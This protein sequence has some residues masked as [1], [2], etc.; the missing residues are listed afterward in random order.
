[1]PKKYDFGGYATK[2]GVKCTDG[3]IINR[4]AF[5]NCNGI[6]VPIVYQHVHDRLENVVGHGDLELRQDGMYVYGKINETPSGKLVKTMI[7]NGDLDSLSIYANQLIQNGPNVTHGVIREVSVVLAGANPQA[8]I[9]DVAIAHADGSYD[10]LE[11]EVVIQGFGN[12]DFLEHAD[13][14]EDSDEETIKDVYNT[15]NDKQKQVVQLILGSVIEEYENNDDDEEAEDEV[16]QS[17]IEEDNTMKKN[18]FAGVDDNTPSVSQADMQN[19]MTSARSLGSFRAAFNALD[20]NQRNAF[21]RHDATTYQVPLANEVRTFTEKA[22][23]VS[24]IGLLFPD[25]RDV[26]N[27]PEWIKRDTEWVAGV[28]NGVRHTPFSHIRTSFADITADEA[29][30]KGYITGHRKTEEVFSVLRRDTTATTVYKKQKF[31]RDDIVDITDFDI[32][33]W[34]QGE[35]RIMLDEEIARAILIGDGR[36][37]SSE[38]KINEGNIRPIWTDDDLYT[39]KFDVS[40]TNMLDVIDEFTYALEDYEGSG[41]LTLYTTKSILNDMLLVRDLNQHRIY[42]GVSELANA[43]GVNRIVTVPVLKNVHRE[44]SGSPKYLY[45]LMVDLRDYTVGTNKGGEIT[46]FQDFDIDYNQQKFLIET[47]MSGALTR[48]RSAVVLE[49]DTQWRAS[50]SN[51]DNADPNVDDE[52]FPEEP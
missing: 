51:S 35:M 52:S 36:S 9:D 5:E 12:L 20:E 11:G 26:N 46:S 16:A 49:G 8:K 33:R 37:V 10:E 2:F 23:G 1:M 21:L 45:G 30:A 32:I 22:Y 43:I 3:R 44:V 39:M 42:N 34:V 24:N 41:N 19:L 40:P 27:P 50:S 25:A 17:D 47:R 7:E 18:V 38:D 31:D 4:E 6:T 28:L 15:L 14:D 48:V 13:D 29:R